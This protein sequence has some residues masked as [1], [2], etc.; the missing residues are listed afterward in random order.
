MAV[1]Q[2]SGAILS[3]FFVG[4]WPLSRDLRESIDPYCEYETH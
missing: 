2:I 4:S 3:A 1:G